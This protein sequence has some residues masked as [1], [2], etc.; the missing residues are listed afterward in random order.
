M[1]ARARSARTCRRESKKNE[2]SKIRSDRISILVSIETLPSPVHLGPFHDDFGPSPHDSR[3][4]TV[5]S[6]R[7]STAHGTR[8]DI[9]VATKVSKQSNAPPMDTPH[10]P[11][12][13]VYPLHAARL[14]RLSRTAVRTLAHARSRAHARACASTPPLVAPTGIGRRCGVMRV[15]SVPE[16]PSFCHL[17]VIK[18]FS[19]GRR[20]RFRA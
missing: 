8:H 11:A 16:E 2:H 12:R 9:P 17:F 19:T 7:E 1:A 15:L 5:V 13:P 14:T 20:R 6:C 4:S 18:A 3:H 10:P